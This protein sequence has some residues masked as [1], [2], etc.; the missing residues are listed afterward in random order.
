VRVLVT[1]AAGFIG[2][3]LAEALLRA[4]HEVASLDNLND[5]Y[6][7]AEKER[8]L[9]EIARAGGPFRSF[10]G[11]LR[12]ADDVRA[13][14]GAA[15]PDAVVHLA[16]MAGVRPSIRDPLLYED[17]NVKGTQVLLEAMREA[18]VKDFV[19]AS[20]SSVYGN[21]RKVPFSEK[22]NV[23]FPISPYA[24]T[25][26]AGE[27][28][29]HT[30]AHLYGF[31]AA[32]L[33]FFTVYG[34]RQRPDLAIRKFTQLILEDRPVPFY[35]DGTTR[36]DYTYVEDTID[37]VVKSLGWLRGRKSPAYEIFNLGESRTVSL[38]EM[39]RCLEKT[40]GKKAKLE[41]LPPQ[42]GDVER[43]CADIRK[44]KKVFGYAPRTDFEEGVARFVEWF[45]ARGGDR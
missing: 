14:L 22:D 5:F 19:F 36:R 16:A 42:P 30:Y 11:D 32:V 31:R 38:A 35:G 28:I 40:I 20:S 29:T 10:R 34:P 2:S 37:G 7:P 45:R 13:A 3:H 33:R 39:V 44:A 27:L 21:N 24:A 23:D 4:G 43:T 12:R 15:R 8:N 25:K 41:R 6:D 9:G 17:V 18:G 26:K 1:G